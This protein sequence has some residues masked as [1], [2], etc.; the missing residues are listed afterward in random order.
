MPTPFVEAVFVGR[1]KTITDDQGTWV[2]S[3]LRDPVVGRIE[4][5][6]RGLAGDAVAQPYHGSPDA[7]VC[8][9]LLDHYSFWNAH[10]GMRLEPGMVGENIT[11]ADMTEDEVCAGDVISLGT[12]ILQ[13]SGPRI[14]CANLG[15]RMG[16]PDWVTLTLNRTAS[17]CVFFSRVRSSAANH[18]CCATGRRRQAPYRRSTAACSSHS[19]PSTRAACSRCRDWANGGRSGRGRSWQRTRNQRKG[20][21][22][23]SALAGIGPSARRT[24]RGSIAT[25]SRIHDRSTSS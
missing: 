4:V 10:L 15:R 7:A 2:S 24:G 21:A 25:A 14:P 12:A 23:G 9:H 1:P 13:V 11:L 20:A 18:G 17:T 19:I 16:R 6:E 8:A 5:A 3:I 22:D